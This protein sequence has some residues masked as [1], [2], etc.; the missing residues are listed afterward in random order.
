MPAPPRANLRKTLPPI[1]TPREVAPLVGL[2]VVS[3]RR[4]DGPLRP[5]RTLGNTRRYRRDAVCDV[6]DALALIRRSR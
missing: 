1:L 4:W 6:I 5:F 2:S 3:L